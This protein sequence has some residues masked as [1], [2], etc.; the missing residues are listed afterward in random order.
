MSGTSVGIETASREHEAGDQSL[1][2]AGNRKVSTSKRTVEEKDK[3]II[4]TSA[5]SDGGP[6]V[7]VT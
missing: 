6:Q 7:S 3:K 1:M 5:N 4:S 2:S